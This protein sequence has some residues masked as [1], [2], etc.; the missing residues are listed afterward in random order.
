MAQVAATNQ[1]VAASVAST[2][3]PLVLMQGGLAQAAT[4]GGKATLALEK[5]AHVAT[6]MGVE[7]VGAGGHLGRLAAQLLAMAGG[8]GPLALAVIAVTGVAL[9]FQKMRENA[10]A[11]AAPLREAQQIIHDLMT[12]TQSAGRGAE[13]VLNKRIG[14]LMSEQAGRAVRIRGQGFNA[15]L[16]EAGL[17]RFSAAYRDAALE[18][19][20]LQA[21]ARS[22]NVTLKSQEMQAKGTTT[23]VRALRD[24]ERELGD[25]L[26]ANLDFFGGGVLANSL[27]EISKQIDQTRKLKLETEA[28]AR[29]RE[30]AFR[31]GLKRTGEGDATAK[32]TF[33]GKQNEAIQGARAA[34]NG[35]ARAFT[36]AFSDNQGTI[37][38]RLASV[39]KNAIQQAIE[40]LIA[41][42][43]F[44]G[45]LSV[46]NPAKDVG[47]IPLIGGLLGFA[48]NAPGAASVGGGTIIVPLDSLPAPLS[49]I[50]YARD[51][52]HTAVWVETARM[53][54]QN[55]VNLQIRRR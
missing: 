26:Q 18:I 35:M 27:R 46:L 42:K 23:S 19:E 22:L 13:A 34:A 5:V 31:T 28:L 49:P 53:V 25:S 17:R 37:M 41:Q 47:I 14:D 3:T 4:N 11:A 33:L 52:Q 12:D 6:I 8:G 10:E 48:P 16:D 39:L 7:T 24:A 2:T 38:E 21:E 20:Q 45:L 43:L 1:R 32:E 55:G 51:A 44:E 36:S 9:A 40:K 54:Q 30:Q 15:G 29:A 50:E